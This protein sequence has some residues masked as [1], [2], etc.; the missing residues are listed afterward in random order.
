MR[1]KLVN[2]IVMQYLDEPFYN[3]LRTNQQLGYVVW[4]YPQICRNVIGNVF[5]IQG[6]KHSCEYLVARINDFLIEFRAKIK[7]LSND[8]FETQKSAVLTA[9]QEKDLNLKD[10]RYRFMMEFDSHQHVFDR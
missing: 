2:K 4:T 6:T 8:E 3:E 10:E 5:L 1:L 9:I 7:E